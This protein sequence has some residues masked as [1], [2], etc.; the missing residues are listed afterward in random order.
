MKDFVLFLALLAFILLHFIFSCF[1]FV[2]F[3]VGIAFSRESS[4]EVTNKPFT[5]LPTP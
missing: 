1:S 4:E 2:V 5:Q 3:L